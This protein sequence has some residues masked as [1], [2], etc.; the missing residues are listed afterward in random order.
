[1]NSPLLL[2]SALGAHNARG[3]GRGRGEGEGERKTDRQIEETEELLQPE[4]NCR[5][6]VYF[7]QLK[8]MLAQ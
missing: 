1:M 4:H 8:G 7:R 3:G 2:C 5:N 6:H